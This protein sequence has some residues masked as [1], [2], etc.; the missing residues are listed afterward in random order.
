MRESEASACTVSWRSAL[1]RLALVKV[2]VAQRGVVEGD[3]LS[4]DRLCDTDLV[5]HYRVHQRPMVPGMRR[6]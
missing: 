2:L 1:D 5:V 3:D 4:I 6:T